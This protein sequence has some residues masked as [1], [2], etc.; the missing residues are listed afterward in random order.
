MAFRRRFRKRPIRQRRFYKRR[1]FKKRLV[2][3]QDTRNRAGRVV[4][5]TAGVPFPTNYFAKLKWNND[6]QITDLADLGIQ[7]TGLWAT[8]MNFITGSTTAGLP[9]PTYFDEFAS[10]YDQ[11]E[12][13]ASKIRVTVIPLGASAQNA[14]ELAVYPAQSGSTLPTTMTVIKSVPLSKWQLNSNAGRPTTITSYLKSKR[15]CPKMNVIT[16]SVVSRQREFASNTLIS[17]S[18]ENPHFRW[19]VAVQNDSGAQSSFRVSV[20]ITY[21]TKIMMKEINQGS[22]QPAP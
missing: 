15:M 22:V 19:I 14:C 9:R 3:R 8:D 7:Q 4:R 12:V 11:Y 18:S 10:I 16:T 17:S 1:T 13:L 21:Y 20:Q 2:S 5:K 6:Y